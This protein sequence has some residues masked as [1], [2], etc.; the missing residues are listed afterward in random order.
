M[1]AIDKIYI[2]TYEQMCQFRDWCNA[3]TLSDKY[4]FSKPLSWWLKNN[5]NK[6]D[7]TT[8][9]GI[10][11]FSAPYPVDYYVIRNC[12][13]DYVQKAMK[14]NYGSQYDEIKNAQ[15]YYKDHIGYLDLETYNYIS[16]ITNSFIDKEIRFCFI[17]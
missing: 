8:E 1:A 2:K 3:H 4:G 5:L 14:I 11:V 12:P 15:G 13:F 10:S 6:F 9:N 16:Y 7:W 17:L